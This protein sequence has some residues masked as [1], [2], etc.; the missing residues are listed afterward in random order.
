MNDLKR[1]MSEVFLRAR[2]LLGVAELRR[3]KME[4]EVRLLSR[5]EEL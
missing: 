4:L 5:L 3:E 2:E 1:R